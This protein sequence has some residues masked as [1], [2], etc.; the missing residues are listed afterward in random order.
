MGYSRLTMIKKISDESVGKEMH[1][2][3]AWSHKS[4]SRTGIGSGSCISFF[5]LVIRIHPWFLYSSFHSSDV[6]FYIFTIELGCF[7]ISRTVTGV[8]SE[9][10]ALARN[11]YT[12]LFGFG[13]CNKLCILVSMAATSYVGLHRFCKMSRHSSPLAYTFGWNIRDRNLTVGGLLG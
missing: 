1:R 2:S 9:L 11:K 5:F 4:E 13:S 10:R 12:Y 8:L 3:L 7:S 6:L